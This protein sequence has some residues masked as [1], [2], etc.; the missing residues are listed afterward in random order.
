MDISNLISELKQGKELAF[1]ELVFGFSGR[2][3]TIARIYSKNEEDAK[4]LL[5]DAFILVFK[6]VSSFE[7]TKEA[8]LYGWMKKIVINLAL[9]RN[10]RKFRTMEHSLDAMGIEK[11]IDEEI[12]AT[13]SHSE[14]MKLIFDLPDGY[15]QVLAL[16]AIE[17]YSHKEVASFLGIRES[18]SRSR[19]SRARKMLQAKYI[20]LNKIMTA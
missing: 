5:Q 2:L 10:Q 18:S 13:L 3:M 15:R 8:A 17:G 19:Y 1:K 14:I 12:I 9:S 7:G 11:M 6:K 16:Y 4:D 20:D